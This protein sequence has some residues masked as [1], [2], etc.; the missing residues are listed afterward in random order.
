MPISRSQMPRQMYGLGSLVKSIG[1][2]VKKIVKSPIGKAALLYGATLP[3]GGPMAAGKSLL[4]SFATQLGPQGTSGSGI[5]GI[6]GKGKNFLSNLTG[7]QKLAGAAGIL[8]LSGAF[9]GMEDEQVEE[10]REKFL[11]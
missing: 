3:F 8:G 11:S 4:G 2:T 7:G 6:L 1:K 9:G 10:L 5:L